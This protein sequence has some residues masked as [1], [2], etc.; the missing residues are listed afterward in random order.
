MKIEN[1]AIVLSQGVTTDQRD[2]LNTL[3]KIVNGFKFSLDFN[4][5]K[6]QTGHLPGESMISVPAN[7]TVS[8]LWEIE[9]KT[10][11]K[12]ILQLTARLIDPDKKQL[13]DIVTNE[14]VVELNSDNFW[15]HLVYGVMH[16]TKAGYY[17]FEVQIKSGES[18]L[19]TAKY[20][21][22][23]ELEEIKAPTI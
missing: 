10:T 1:K 11:Q 7:F 14:I 15:V 8:G 3:F 13:G 5:V 21:I 20:R 17:N 2:K 23:V 16:I 22:S 19:S 6:L 9:K 12:E 4:A 18:V